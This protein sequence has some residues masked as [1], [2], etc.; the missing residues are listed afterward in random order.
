[1]KKKIAVFS[2]IVLVI[3]G[4]SVLILIYQS[5]HFR[6][7]TRTLTFENTQRS[8]IIHTPPNYN[9]VSKVPLVIALHGY[10]Q[11][12]KFFELDSGLSRLA[13]QNNFIVVYPFGTEDNKGNN[14]SWN[15]GACCDPA[16]KDQVN[17]IGF[18]KELIAQI[19]KDE[20]IK[21]SKIYVIGFSN[22]G[23]LAHKIAA[24]LDDTVAAVAVV[25]GSIGGTPV[26][27]ST[28]TIADS[29]SPV[30]IV[31]IHGRDD[32]TVSY[33]GDLSEKLPITFKSFQESSTFWAL[34]DGC[35]LSSS[36]IEKNTLY[37]H[38]EFPLCLYNSA[39]ETYT[40]LNS[41]HEW[42]GGLFA[43]IFHPFS[44]HFDATYRIWLFL[45]Q[46][47]KQSIEEK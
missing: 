28:Y 45:S 32:T 31:M 43:R 35:S 4:L 33:T 41:G 25:G 23:I 40:V 36:L 30:P 29:S 39:V 37:I 13:D 14:R 38:S 26:G 34:V 42:F 8:Y 46:Y 20:A 9:G 15:A 7:R 2:V 24:Q 11:H 19:Q 12:P 22:G 3:L 47:P 17:D 16:A 10:Q 18:I 5:T 6:S 21:G 1:M 27:D 44:D